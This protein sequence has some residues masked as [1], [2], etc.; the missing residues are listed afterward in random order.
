MKKITKLLSIVM[1]LMFVMAAFAGCG[2][3]DANKTGGND[4]QQ[5]TP[6]ATDRDDVIIAT[7]NEPP[8]MHPYDHNAVAANYMNALTF[9]T[10]FR[11]NV[12]TLEPE[13]MLATGY[14]ILSDTQWKI[15]LRKDVKFHNGETMTADDVKASMEWAKND[16]S[17]LT[18]I[19][20]SWWKDI[21]VVDPTTII[22]T[23]NDVYAKT[24]ID[25][26]RMKIVPK[27]LIDSG[28]DFNANPVG[29]GPYKFVK[30]TLGDSIEFEAFEDY[31][32]G[33]PAIKHMTWRI[34]PEGS[35]RTIA[36]EAGEVDFVVEVE[37]ND[38]TRLK[39]DTDIA[40]LDQAGTS[41]NYMMVNNEKAPFNNEKFRKAL[42][43]A[44]DKD[45]VVQVALNGAG[46]GV[47]AQ[48]PNVLSGY[49]DK[50]AE[51]FDLELAKK[52]IQ[53]SGIDPKTVTFSCICSD[54]TKR[55]AGEVIQ[56]NLAE[57]GITMNLESMDLATYLSATAEGN[58][59]AAIGGY[60]SSDMMSFIEGVYHSKSINGSN[61]TRLNDAEVDKLYNLATTQLD[62]TERNKTLEECSARVN[63][64]C[65]QATLYQVNVVRAYN[66]ALQGVAVSASGTMYWEYVSWAK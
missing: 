11:T 16:Y 5:G 20:T 43:C 62:S 57:L 46:T 53:E 10:L 24:L 12:E 56:A 28:N 3:K 14:E 33:A 35:S 6:T 26:T 17:S 59:E 44:I 48:V 36:L 21:Q 7:A 49:S 38:L 40:V 55:R 13:P 9:A 63:S 31:F 25:L 4:N 50:N 22:I 64:L 47:S 29:A 32:D 66:N 30:W 58:Y 8:T 23:T 37:T 19:Y 60:T 18:N 52:Y 41:F 1:A 2:S 45:A 27:S 61:K 42:N 34:I 39:A 15:T 51:K 65:P 54:D